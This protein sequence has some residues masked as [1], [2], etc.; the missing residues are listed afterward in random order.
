[1]YVNINDDS[2]GVSKYNI[3]VNLIVKPD[4]EMIRNFTDSLF[5]S[6]S[7]SITKS[8]INGDLKSTTAFINSFTLMLDTQTA[9]SNGSDLVSFVK[10]ITF[11]NS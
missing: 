4:Q 9:P 3:P 11:I 8:L 2:D 6:N 10:F 7:E 1:M 5:G